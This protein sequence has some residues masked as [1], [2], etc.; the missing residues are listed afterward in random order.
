MHLARD[1]QGRTTPQRPARGGQ[2]GRSRP[3]ALVCEALEPRW[4]LAGEWLLEPLE[5][6]DAWGALVSTA[7]DADPVAEPF[8]VS[9]TMSE[10][11]GPLA[12]SAS[13]GGFTPAQLRHA[14]GFDQIF[15]DGGTLEGDGTGQTIAIVNAYHAPT[16]AADLAAFD[17]Y[18]GLPAPASFVQVDQNGG[19]NYPGTNSG[20]ALETALDVQW[21]HAFAPG[22]DILLVEAN[23]A[24][25]TNLMT[26]VDYARNQPGVSVVS[27]SW[28]TAGEFANETNYDFHFATPE[29]HAGVTFFAAAGNDGGPG[30]YPAYSP[31]VVAVGGTSLSLNGSNN[32]ASESAWSGS[33]GGVS[34]YEAQPS[35][36]NGVVTQ[37]STQRA[38]PD[39]AF[40]ANPSTGV[41]VYETFNNSASTPWTKVAG[42]SFATPSWGALVAIAD[43]GRTLAGLPVLDMPGLMST[44]YAMPATNF[45]DITTGASGGSTPQSAGPGYD[46]VTGRGTP[47]A[48]L[49]AASLVGEGSVTGTVFED[50]NGNGTLDGEPALGGW[51]VYADL[52]ENGAFDPIAIDDFGSGDVPKSISTVGG[53][54][55]TSASAVS[56]LAGHI[57]D[58]NVTLNISH[59]RAGDLVITLIAP[60][61]S[62]YVL[63]SHVGGDGDNF[64]DTTFDDSAANQIAS[65]SAPFSGSFRPAGSL[66]ALFDTNP[67]GTWQLRVQ[68]TVLFE[69]GSLSSWSLEITTGDLSALSEADGTYRLGGLPEG[70]YQIREVIKS[71]FTQTA[72]TSGFYTVNLAAGQGATGRDFGNQQPP[73]GAA[74]VVGRFLFYNQSTFDGNDGATGAADDAAMATDKV[75]YLPGAGIATAASVSSY[76]RGINGIM[77]DVAN[78]SGTIAADDFTFRLGNNDTPG[79]WTA[80][81]DPLAVVVRAGAGVGGSDRVEIVWAERVI[82]N[83]WLAVIVEGNDAAGGF[84]TNTG[85]AASDVFFF[86]SRIGDTANDNSPTSL[87]TNAADEI[88]VRNNPGLGATIANQYDF[89]RNGVVNASDQ[90]IARS[91]GGFITRINISSP[92]AAPEAGPSALAEAEEG[93]EEPL[94]AATQPREL[95]PGMA[96]ALAAEHWR[97]QLLASASSDDWLSHVD[98]PLVGLLAGGR[99]RFARR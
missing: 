76:S 78:A 47:K 66:A 56:G 40:D 51:T 65:G 28:G 39:V 23:S 15:F 44:L 83:T 50:V 1:S 9:A 45:N 6:G 95:D 26:A 16:A 35:W 67:N 96:F 8:V 29:N 55:V 4:L 86:G 25:F 48:H 68:D 53:S 12:G 98:E 38:M 24:T 92:P 57:I 58:V 97:R 79:T 91:N 62:A 82:A 75:A 99:H 60:D 64:A 59:T 34:Q 72:P 37:T 3:I 2:A 94:G 21:A 17:A 71:P 46:L 18:F 43:Q 5:S 13:P 10:E 93:G 63:A 33:G 74:S 31:N 14:Y 27:M 42:T 77:V 61:N 90:I 84:N 73:T 20:W 19:T 70:A 52:N 22:A 81:L 54:T 7:L 85:L 32:I 89:D 69:G 41:P 80:A 87:L 49:V 30:G 88:A 11:A 36:Q